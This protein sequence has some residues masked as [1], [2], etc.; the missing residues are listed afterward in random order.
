MVSTIP[1]NTGLVNT[2]TSSIYTFSP[3]G[4]AYVQL[5]I[6]DSGWTF[7]GADF[8]WVAHTADNSHAWWRS[9]V[10]F[11][12]LIT[13]VPQGGTS[14]PPPERPTNLTLTQDYLR[15][16]HADQTTTDSAGP[17]EYPDAQY[18]SCIP[19]TGTQRWEIRDPRHLPNGANL[20][21][22]YGT[23]MGPENDPTQDFRI[24]LN[25]NWQIYYR[26]VQ[27]NA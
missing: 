10:A 22:S 2:R 20:W 24:Y 27:P 11:A 25:L 1:I 15:H 21:F 8:S 18:W 12:F 26:S 5:A 4:W 19:R 3:D 16:E 7:E 13:Y 9:R 6:F 14:A 23:T 17:L